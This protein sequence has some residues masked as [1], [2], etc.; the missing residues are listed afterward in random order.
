MGMVMTGAWA[1][2]MLWGEGLNCLGSLSAASR[3]L[4]YSGCPTVAA[5][6]KGDLFSPAGRHGCYKGLHKSPPACP[7]F[8]G[9]LATVIDVV[10]AAAADASPS[11]DAWQQQ[12]QQQGVVNG[13]GSR[14]GVTS[15]VAVELLRKESLAGLQPPSAAKVGGSGASEWVGGWGNVMVVGCEVVRL[16]HLRS[17]HIGAL[18]GLC[19]W[20]RSSGRQAMLAAACRSHGLRCA[21]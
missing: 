7:Q 1:C 16:C 21:W 11:S 2:A 20:L 13:A 4:F 8:A 9:A 14:S 18:P 19:R 12:Q 5:T 6:A 15:S 17:Q 10:R 3:V